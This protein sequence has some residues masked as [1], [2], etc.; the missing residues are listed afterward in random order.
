MTFEIPYFKSSYLKTFFTKNRRPIFKIYF[1]YGFREPGFDLGRF[2]QGTPKLDRWIPI[3]FNFCCESTESPDPIFLGAIQSRS[4][5]FGS[6]PILIR[7]K[8][9]ESPPIR[10]R[11]N[12]F[13]S[14]PIL[15]KFFWKCA[16]R[17]FWQHLLKFCCVYIH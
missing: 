1:N 8:F 5:F 7:S 16:D 6:Y 4:N 14:P 12:F 9:S 3:R 2:D 11:S 17:W 13:P 10:S 15:S